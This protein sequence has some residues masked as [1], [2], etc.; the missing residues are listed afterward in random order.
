LFSKELVNYKLN[1]P[2][3]Y[4]PFSSLAETKKCESQFCLAFSSLMLKGGPYFSHKSYTQ[5]QRSNFFCH[6]FSISDLKEEAAGIKKK[7]F[8][9]SVP[10]LLHRQVSF[11]L[12]Y[13][14]FYFLLLFNFLIVLMEIVLFLVLGICSSVN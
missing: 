14:L 3:K 13:A 9:C 6:S 4:E 10:V 11:F 8:L 2:D 5:L 1:K 12:C 7:K